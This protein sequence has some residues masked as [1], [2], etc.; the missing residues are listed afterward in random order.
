MLG[1]AIANEASRFP[2]FDVRAPGRD[3][4]D[5]RDAEAVNRWSGWLAH[6]WIVHCAACVDVEGCARDPDAARAT[7]VEGTRNVAELAARCGARVLY[8]QSFLVYDGKHNPIPENEEARPLSLYGQLKHEAEKVLCARVPS[9]LILRM[10]GFFGGQAADKNFV[11][12]I[13]PVIHAAIL[14]GERRFEVGTRT[15][16]PTWTQDLAANSLHLMAR[17]ATGCYQMA[18]RGHATFAEVAHEV[19]RGLGWKHRIEIVPVDASSVT[20]NELGRRPDKAI[21]SCTRLETEHMNL[22]RDWRATLD[23]YLSHPFFDKYRME[24]TL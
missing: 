7:I 14:R 19:V 9:P 15:W 17:D 21:L 2:R 8:P 6:G 12:R 1:L 5:V 20:Q 24:S 11:G 3:E 23:A 22:Q 13:I 10:A 18:C 16:Q 4:L